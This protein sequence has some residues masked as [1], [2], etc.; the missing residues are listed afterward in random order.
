MNKKI[1]LLLI[2][3]LLAMPF[4]TFAQTYYWDD[5]DSL[6]M[7]Y[8]LDDDIWSEDEEMK[9]KDENSQY[10]DIYKSDCGYLFTIVIDN[11]NKMEKYGTRKQ[12]DYHLLN[13]TGV[14]NAM[15]DTVESE[16]L[17]VSSHEVKTYDEFKYLLMKS[18]INNNDL[19]TYITMN[20]GNTLGFYYVGDISNE[21]L[22]KVDD[23]LN[24]SHSYIQQSGDDIEI[25]VLDTI[26]IIGIIALFGFA[27][28]LGYKNSKEKDIKKVLSVMFPY[29]I[30]I[31]VGITLAGTSYSRC[32]NTLNHGMCTLF[33]FDQGIF[34]ALGYNFIILIGIIL[35]FNKAA[36]I[37]KPKKD[38]SNNNTK[39]ESDQ[40]RLY[41]CSKC[42]E[43]FD[44]DFDVCP[45]CK[46]DFINNTDNNDENTNDNS[47]TC[48]N[49][50]ASVSE[51]AEECPNCGCTFVEEEKKEEQ[52]V[53]DNCGALVNS[54]AK[55]C[56]NC[57]ETFEEEQEKEEKK[58]T[59]RKISNTK[60]ETSD[61]DK[62]YDDLNK[63]KKLLDKKIITKEEFEK[64]KKKILNK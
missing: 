7:E 6:Q 9:S 1:L 52:F 44:H 26:F 25:S 22:S 28:F 31:G 61:M 56:P 42:G 27:I 11:Y 45:N 12:I 59:N 2:I 38:K 63:L 43:T 4:N 10:D 19:Y 60:K 20:N 34:Y 14:V 13:Q 35:A 30:I 29:V 3:M 50:G 24:S 53:C 54:S 17:T 40:K 55:K 64:E 8:T 46:F 18:N 36:K 47:F 23:V 58:K 49:C 51:D 62:K 57:G 41:K 5:E 15:I 33:K 32:M 37:N 39:L 48:D 16:G 21:C